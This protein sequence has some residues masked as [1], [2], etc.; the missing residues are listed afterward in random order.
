MNILVTGGAGYIG[1][2]L[3]QI[4]LKNNFNVTVLDNFLFKQKSLNQIKKNRQ[5]NIVE[6]DVRDESIIKD[7]VTKS[8]IIIPL[9]ALVGAPLCDIKPKEAKE[10]NLDSMFLL[11]SILSKNQRVILPVSNSGYGIGK[12]GEFCTEESPLNPISLYGQTKVQSESI[13]MERENSISFRLATVFGM[14]PRMRIDLLVNYFVNK[15]LTEKKIQIFEGHFKRNY[16]HIKDVA[17]VFLF[18]IKNFEKMKSNTYNF[19][20]E[21]ANFSKIELAEKIK[22]YI[23]NFEIQISEFGKDPDKRDYIV[24]NKKILST[25]YKFLED[26]DSGIQELIR[27]IPNLSKNESYSN[28]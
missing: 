5:L 27:E 17:N 1:S 18:T 23:N 15:A 24:S 22:K 3:V 16:V 26:L 10:V 4:L 14:S 19:G 6:G 7:L 11:K 8:D 21:D 9:A 25:G 12:S 20:L 13:I 28:V 2:V